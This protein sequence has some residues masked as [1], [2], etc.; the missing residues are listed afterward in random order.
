MRRGEDMAKKTLDE[1]TEDEKQNLL[2]RFIKAPEEQM[3][4]QEVVALFL[5]CSI[6][7][8][9]RMRCQRSAIPYTKIGRTVVYQKKNVLEYM[10]DRTIM[11]TA[12][13]ATI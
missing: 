4:P 2:E 7:T 1:M 11:N 13:L 12:Q 3:F 10:R 8:L 6:H 5:S 9:Q